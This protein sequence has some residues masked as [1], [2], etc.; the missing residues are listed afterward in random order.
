MA[1]IQPPLPHMSGAQVL[2][3]RVEKLGLTYTTKPPLITCP[4][5]IF[6]FYDPRPNYFYLLLSF[7]DFPEQTP[8]SLIS[9]PNFTSSSSFLHLTSTSSL[10]LASFYLQLKIWGRIHPFY[11]LSSELVAIAYSPIL[12]YVMLYWVYMIVYGWIVGYILGF[13]WLINE[14]IKEGGN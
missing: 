5:V 14:R 11:L 10:K 6:I 3:N 13:D 8:F 4:W 1:E 9:F 7:S 12:M 2:L